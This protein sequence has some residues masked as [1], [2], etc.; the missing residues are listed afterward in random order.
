MGKLV[1][2]DF[3]AISQEKDQLKRFTETSKRYTD[4]QNKIVEL[5]I[6][7]DLLNSTDKQLIVMGSIRKILSHLDKQGKLHRGGCTHINYYNAMCKI[8]DEGASP[9]EFLF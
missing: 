7:D 6:N 3:R 8:M 2:L 5:V 4:L 1:N 9:D